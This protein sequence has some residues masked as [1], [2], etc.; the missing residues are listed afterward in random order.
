[1]AG[2]AAARASDGNGR[3]KTFGVKRCARQ[4]GGCGTEGVP[5]RPGGSDS[6]TQDGER[7]GGVRL[8]FWSNQNWDWWSGGWCC[9]ANA[10]T[11]GLF[12]SYRSFPAY[13]SVTKKRYSL[14]AR[15]NLQDFSLDKD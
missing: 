9:I 10:L 12:Y 4:P 1:M 8:V 6:R 7:G 15:K 3:G 5:R 11:A 2:G 14:I 13:P